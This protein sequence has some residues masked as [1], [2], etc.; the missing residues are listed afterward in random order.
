MSLRK[1]EI[2]EGN[3]S[4]NPFHA[5]GLLRYPLKTSEDLWFSDVFWGIERDQ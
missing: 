4:V 5:T 3:L 2:K 1:V